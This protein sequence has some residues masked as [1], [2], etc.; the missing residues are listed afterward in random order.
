MDELKLAIRTRFIRNLI[1]KVLAKVIYKKTG[2]HVDI[3]INTIEAETYGEKMRF[4]MDIN[5][6]MNSEDLID[7]L[8]KSDLL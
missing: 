2:Y 1:T 7:A 6:E 3:Q 4:H 5:A 8:R